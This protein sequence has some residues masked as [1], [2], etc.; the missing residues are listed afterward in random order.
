MRYSHSHL[1]KH[2][3]EYDA[4]LSSS[5]LEYYM[6][7]REAKLVEALIS[8]ISAAQRGRYLDFAC[9]S[10][11]ILSI[12]SPYF[13]ETVAV[14]VSENMVQTARA[15]VPIATFHLVDITRQELN[16]G[17]FD[18]ISAFRFFG[19]AEDSLRRAVL[20][21]LRARIKRNGFLLINNHRNPSS[22]L[23]RISG[24]GQGMDLDY[25]KFQDLLRDHGFRIVKRIPIGTWIL[26]HRWC[27]QTVWDSAMGHVGDRLT[28]IPFLARFSPDMIILAK[29][30]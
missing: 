11:R 25:G 19:N 20:D 14:D 22:F 7:V 15:K 10:G 29:P 12:I 18:L 9:G 26:R 17:Q 4:A 5:G 2:G 16:I 1:E 23:A 3:N 27:E 13:R 30:V 24:C 21:A 6:A 8:G 28:K